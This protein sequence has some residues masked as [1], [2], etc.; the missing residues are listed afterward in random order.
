MKMKFKKFC[1]L[2]V[3]PFLFFACSNDSGETADCPVCSDEEMSMIYAFEDADGNSTVSYPGQVVR[4]LLVNDIKSAGANRLSMYENDDENQTR[5]IGAYSG[6]T[7][8]TV[9]SDFKNP[10][11]TTNT[12]N[13]SGKIAKQ[14]DSF[15]VSDATVYGYDMEPD[16]LMK[17]W[18]DIGNS[19]SYTSTG[20]DIGQMVQKGL[21]GVVSYY[22]GTSKYL[23]LVLDKQNAEASDASAGKYYTD[24]EHYWDESFGY[25]GASRNY[26]ERTDQAIY[27]AY[28]HDINE[29]G[30]IDYESEYCTGISVNAVK[31]D[32]GS[33]DFYDFHTTI[34]HA[35][36]TGRELISS[37]VAGENH[38]AIRVQRSIIVN[39]WEMLLAANAIHYIND[40]MEAIGDGSG[41]DTS[42]DATCTTSDASGKCS[43]YSK[44]FSEMRGF[45]MGLQYNTFK[46]ISD[47]DLNNVYDLMRVAPEFPATT[48][49]L[50]G[51]VAYKADLLAARDILEEAYGFDTDVVSVW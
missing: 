21:M 22:Q 7:V 44:Y 49:D 13:L 28:H 32:L 51:M 34:M 10:D 16:D 36:L 14:S 40:T 38:A 31:R 15:G 50:T 1:T 30:S 2:I 39:N 26:L 18:F 5:A 42:W 8:Q 41:W 29:D 43:D 37:D 3:I 45:A 25:F 23:G 46:L 27:D 35:Y 24:M 19:A 4:N 20:L 6:T 11:G 9:Y 48:G 47:I 17:A 12:S 33:T